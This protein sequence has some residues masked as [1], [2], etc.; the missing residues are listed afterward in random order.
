MKNNILKILL[1]LPTLS[2]A[3][4]PEI[5][6]G[7]LYAV[8][9]WAAFGGEM[10]KY[11]SEFAV[12]EINA[13]GG[14]N[15]SKIKLIIEDTNSD[16]IKT[17]NG[18]KKLTEVDNVSAIVGPNFAEFLEIVAPAATQSQIPIISPNGF[19]RDVFNKDGFIF[20]LLPPDELAVKPLSDKIFEMKLKKVMP[21]VSKNAFF[22]TQTDA[23][24]NDLLSKGLVLEP[25]ILVDG[26]ESDFRSI[27]LKLKS[28]GVDGI[29]L[30]LVENSGSL[31]AFFKQANALKFNI[32]LFGIGENI[33]N[34]DTVKKSLSIAENTIYNRYKKLGSPAFKENFKNRHN[35]ET[36]VSSTFAYDAVYAIKTAI[37]QCGSSRPQIK[38][39][40]RKINFQ[41]E[42]GIVSFDEF[43]ITKKNDDYTELAEVR[44]R[45]I[46]T[47][48]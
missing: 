2:T 23:I 29:I 9:G 37:Q 18:F 28:S 8:S 7:A 19:K 31:P 34:D 21:I 46:N 45:K 33:E 43:G 11:G 12:D 44:D 22:Q 15:G 3:E 1:L 25:D 48:Q 30:S 14:I 24:R 42:S 10:S 13:S 6:I 4:Q 38:N 20:S 5:K 17:I 26:N 35:I 32:Q 39:C 36:D 41:G 16:N 27:I 47:I 40:L